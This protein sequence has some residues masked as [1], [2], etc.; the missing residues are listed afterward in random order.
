MT[1]GQLPE[2]L[3]LDGPSLTVAGTPLENGNFSVNLQFTNGTNT[4]QVG[5]RFF[6]AGG[7]TGAVVISTGGNLG[8]V[9]QGSTYSQQ[10]SACCAASLAGSFPS[11]LDSLPPNLT[12]SQTGVLGGIVTT[13]GTYKFTLRVDSAD[14]ATYAQRVFTLI[15]TPLSITT[16]EAL[17][18]G[19][20]QTPYSVPLTVTGA[21][22]AVTWTVAPN[23][24][25]PP[26]LSIGLTIGGS[27]AITGTPLVSGRFSFTINVMDSAMPAHIATRSFTVSIYPV[28]A[29]P[30]LNWTQG[31]NLGTFGVGVTNIQFEQRHGRVATLSILPDER[32]AWDA[33]A[34]QPRSVQRLRRPDPPVVAVPHSLSPWLT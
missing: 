33:R 21:T 34:E 23:N 26:G 1:G 10:F 13:A 17:S 8:V 22:G 6:I 29:F 19:N 12:L 20:V 31:Q 5:N 4:L 30:P 15:V 9:T 25:V 14:P 2:G 3:S 28:G 7:G 16:N 32:R 18:F 11:G 24:Y 27:P